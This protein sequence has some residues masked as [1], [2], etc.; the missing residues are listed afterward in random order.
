MMNEMETELCVKHRT[1]W[2]LNYIFIFI[3]CI[4][5]KAVLNVYVVQDFLHYAQG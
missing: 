4:F 1:Q 5:N 2:N 3:Y